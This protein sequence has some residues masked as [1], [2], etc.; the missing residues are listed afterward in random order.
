VWNS[1]LPSP[2][3]G[4]AALRKRLGQTAA[5]YV[6]ENLSAAVLARHTADIYDR[7]LEI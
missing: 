5:T 3:V 2:L 7:L 4:D 1:S 6:H